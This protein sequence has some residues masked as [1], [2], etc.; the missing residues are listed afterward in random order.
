MDEIVRKYIRYTM[1][2]KHFTPDLVVDL[3]HLRK[4]SMLADAEVTEVLNEVSRRIVRQRGFLFPFPAGFSV[5]YNNNL[6]F[7]KKCKTQKE[8][9][10]LF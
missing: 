10:I 5:L 3:I 2:E 8:K 7:K 1:N 4:E 9:L 6:V